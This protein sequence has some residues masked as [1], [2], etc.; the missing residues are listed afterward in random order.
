M[1]VAAESRSATK[2]VQDASADYQL[3]RYDLGSFRGRRTPLGG[4]K[5]ENFSDLLTPEAKGKEHYTFQ[6]QVR[7]IG[8]EPSG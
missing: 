6:E 1:V 5:S 2:A 4:A 8:H 7:A 3:A